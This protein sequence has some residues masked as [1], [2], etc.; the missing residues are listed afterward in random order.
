MTARL[1]TF[2]GCNSIVN[3][4][5]DGTSPRCNVHKRDTPTIPRKKLYDHQY[6]K[7]GSL[8]YKT[9]EW[10]RVRKARL[11]LNPLCQHHEKLGLVKAAEHVDH[12]IEILDG[13]KPYDLNNTQSLCQACHNTK[14]ALEKR[15]RNSSKNIFPSLNNFK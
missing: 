15:K 1:C 9:K 4:A 11:L 14:T 6:D 10:K 7:K 12:I 8:I 13:G 2:S 5:D 3:H